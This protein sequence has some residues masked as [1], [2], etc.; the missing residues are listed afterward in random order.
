[1]P[2]EPREATDRDHPGPGRGGW[3]LPLLSLALGGILWVASRVGVHPVAGLAMFA[4]MAAFGPGR[5]GLAAL[6]LLSRTGLSGD[7][8]RPLRR[9]SRGRQQRWP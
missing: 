3:S 7:L 8:H 2:T 1:M 4:V 5:A 9:G 6:A